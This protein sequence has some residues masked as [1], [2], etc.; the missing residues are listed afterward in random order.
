ME[1]KFPQEATS[2]FKGIENQGNPW[3]LAQE[4]RAEWAEGLEIPQMAE[5][6]DPARSTCCTG[7]DAR[8]RTMS[9]IRRSAARSQA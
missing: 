2:A 6:E 3:G 4:K 1:I 8:A 9:A 5:L 7:S